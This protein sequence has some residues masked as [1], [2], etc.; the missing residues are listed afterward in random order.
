MP[1]IPNEHKK[2][3]M[4]PLSVEHGGEVFCYPDE[5]VYEINQYY[6]D[7]INFI[8]YG[9]DSYEEYFDLI[10]EYNN[11]TEDDHLK[12]LFAELKKEIIRLNRKEEWSICRYIGKKM[13]TIKG[14][15]PGQCYYWPCCADDPVYS[16]V[17]DN[18]EFTSYWYP[19]DADLWEIVSDPTGMAE[20][21]INNPD[22]ENTKEEFNSVMRELNEDVWTDI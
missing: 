15:E 10:D 2:Y 11:N 9:Y 16:G 17:I 7:V 18:E 21:E 8:P 5:L 20:R 13:S 12:E 3:N 14:L 22:K 4:L 6:T 1:Y 19:T